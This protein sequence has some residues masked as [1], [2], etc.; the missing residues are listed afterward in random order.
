MAHKV[1]C[2]YC[3]EKFDRDK[4]EAVLVKG[5]RYA[6]KACALT[7]EEKRS[8][9]EK[10]LEDLEN[11]I[12][13]LLNISVIDQKIKRQINDYVSKYNYTYSGIKKALIYFYEVK[14]N[15]TEKANGGIGIVGYCYRQAYEYY[16]ALWEAQQKTADVKIE[17]YVPMVKEIYITRPQRKI[18]KKKMFNFL[19]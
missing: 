12:K 7:E 13:R 15:S 16:Y 18:R 8:Q 4:E 1:I 9:D 17:T 2:L 10:D 5:K 19:D 11:Y 14:G 6:H 3:G